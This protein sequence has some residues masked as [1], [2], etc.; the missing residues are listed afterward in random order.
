M[1]TYVIGDVQGCY[2]ELKKLVRLFDFNPAKDT[3]WFCGDLVNRGPHSL[4]VLRFV[5]DLPRKVVVLGNHDIH[6]LSVYEKVQTQKKLDTLSVVLDAPDVS[7]LCKW[8]RCQPLLH[9]DETEKRVLVHAGFAP[10]WD[11]SLAKQCAD[12]VTAALQGE[13]YVEVLAGLYGNEPRLWSSDLQGMDRLRFSVNCFTRMRFCEKSGAIDF[14]YKGG[15][16]SAP[17][18]LIPWF[19]FP[20]RLSESLT[21]LFGHWSALEGKIRQK[22]VLALDTGCIWGGSLSALCLD[23]GKIYQESCVAYAKDKRF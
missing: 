19:S 21:I 5:S 6:L 23:T 4:E 10:Q 16:A 9:V 15:L 14:D 8:L 11:L 13:N 22:N 3:L 20:G 1:A 12:E 7:L 2:H 17:D 18:S